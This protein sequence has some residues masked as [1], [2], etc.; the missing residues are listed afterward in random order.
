MST[1]TY[2]GTKS[3]TTISDA[4]AD[5]LERK[6]SASKARQAREDAKAEKLAEQISLAKERLAR[7]ED[8]QDLAQGNARRAHH[9]TQHLTSGCHE[10]GLPFGLDEAA[11]RWGI[12][13]PGTDDQL[14]AADGS[15]ALRC[16]SCHAASRGITLKALKA[17]R[18][19]REEER[20][21]REL[22]QW[23][24]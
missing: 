22:A 15:W 20:A 17:E 5:R 8:A 7:L 2:T 10:C 1:T 11:S 3:S 6:I 24:L 16:D 9:R 21:A 19:A 14:E 23:G 13:I 18:T 12:R 4:K